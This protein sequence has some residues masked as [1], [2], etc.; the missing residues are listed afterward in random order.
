MPPVSR[1]ILFYENEDL[2]RVED[3]VKK[4]ESNRDVRRAIA[5]RG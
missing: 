3:F 5:T 2:E 4:G 1:S